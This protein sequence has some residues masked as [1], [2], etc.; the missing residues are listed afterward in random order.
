[1]TRLRGLQ[2]MMASMAGP[3]KDPKLIAET[4]MIDA[5]RN[6]LARPRGPPST[7]ALGIRTSSPEWAP[8]GGTAVEKVRCLMTG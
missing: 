8:D 1:M 3:D 5:G 7:F 6:A 4:L 2:I